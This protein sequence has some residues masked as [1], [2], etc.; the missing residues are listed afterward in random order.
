MPELMSA[1]GMSNKGN[2][3]IEFLSTYLYGFLLLMLPLVFIIMSANKLI[4]GYIDNGSTAYL[5]ATPNC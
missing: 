4:M 3:L 1:F 5:I 2:T